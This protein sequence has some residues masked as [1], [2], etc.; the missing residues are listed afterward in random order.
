[1]YINC[2]NISASFSSL[3]DV[4]AV[5]EIWFQN[6]ISK[7]TYKLHGYYSAHFCR[8][9]GYGDTSIHT[10]QS[11]LYKVLLSDSHSFVE[12]IVITFGSVIF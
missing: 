10:K 2:W 5:Q 12:Y 7:P 8:E 3:P 11:A 6:N 9:D 1:M 4:I